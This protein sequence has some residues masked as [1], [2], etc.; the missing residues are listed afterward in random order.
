MDIH[1]F[2]EK[3]ALKITNQWEN[4]F[5]NS[6]FGKQVSE[7]TILLYV[8]M[9]LF[10]HI[11][12]IYRMQDDNKVKEKQIEKLFEITLEDLN[13]KNS[14]LLPNEADPYSTAIYSLNEIFEKRN[15]SDMIKIISTATSQ[16]Y[17]SISDYNN[18]EYS[19]LVISKNPNSN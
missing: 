12:A 2:S 15:P 14:L 13:V 16:I 7:E 18:I 9:R 11:F 4:S 8:A 17:Q 3:L 1:L 5:L 6:E 10:D 19:P